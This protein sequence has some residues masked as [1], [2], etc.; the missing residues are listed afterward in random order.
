[1]TVPSSARTLPQSTSDQSW[2]GFFAYPDSIPSGRC[3]SRA[4]RAAA[5]RMTARTCPA[6]TCTSPLMGNCAVASR[7]E[8]AVIAAR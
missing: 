3:T 5:S 1:M 2:I 4:P 8:A 7:K 6:F